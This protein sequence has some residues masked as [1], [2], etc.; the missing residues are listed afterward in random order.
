MPSQEPQAHPDPDL[1]CSGLC[2]QEK[3]PGSLEER[4]IGKLGQRTRGESGAPC[5]AR[6]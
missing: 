1:G 3:A 4:M 2:C 5:G 6:E